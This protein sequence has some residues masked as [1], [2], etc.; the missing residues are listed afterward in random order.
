[1]NFGPHF[2]NLVLMGSPLKHGGK[3]DD[4]RFVVTGQPGNFHTSTDAPHSG[5]N[6]IGHDNF[7]T[8]I[9]ENLHPLNTV[10]RCNYL[11]NI[12]TECVRED[13]Q[14]KGVII[15]EENFGPGTFHRRL[16]ASRIK[17]GSSYPNN[18]QN[19]RGKEP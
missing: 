3:K 8:M 15:D 14:E 18:W 9:K 17:A 6:E 2:R 11:K 5:H 12:S 1:M 13:F 7:R 16:S 19:E 4:N 10:T